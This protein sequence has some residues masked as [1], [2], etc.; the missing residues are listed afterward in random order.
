MDPFDLG[1]ICPLF[2]CSDRV[3]MSRLVL[4]RVGYLD[5]R[6]TSRHIRLCLF[7]ILF[8]FNNFIKLVG[9]LKG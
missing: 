8:A 1:K 2:F 3:Y 7:F 9:H 5:R 6:Y 4:S